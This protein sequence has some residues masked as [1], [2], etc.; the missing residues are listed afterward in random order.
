LE[1]EL[2]QPV[3]WIEADPGQV[4]QL[5]LN[6]AIN[7]RDAMPQGGTLGIQTANVTFTEP[8]AFSSGHLPAGE[9]ALLSISDTGC[10]MGA[11]VQAHLFEPFFTTK[12]T[13]KGTGLGL[14]N[15]YGVVKQSGGD[16]T[17]TSAVGCGTTFRIYLPRFEARPDEE[18]STQLTPP[19]GEGGDETVL[20]VEDEELVR[21]MLV[22]VL[23]A[24]GY[25]VLDARHGADALAL[26]DQF[27]EPIDLL[28]TD[29]TM[30]GFSGSELARRL[31]EKRPSMRVLFISGYTDQEAAH[32][33]KLNQPVHFLQ[34]P[35]HPDAFLTRARQI[36]DRAKK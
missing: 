7:A 9:Y 34:K 25:S 36:L 10:G 11:E 20:L 27:K 17:V 23:K 16:I 4:E 33:D 5:I 22:E 3:P 32:W 15:V 29:M 21:M 12:E 2:A 6:L 28:V 35:F 8:K 31:G 24:A 30:P 13:G 18:E 1:I 19:V 14:C 26:A